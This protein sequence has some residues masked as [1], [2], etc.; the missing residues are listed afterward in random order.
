MIRVRLGASGKGMS[1]VPPPAAPGP[2]GPPGPIGPPGPGSDEIIYFGDFSANDGTYRVR[3]LGGSGTFR[4][5]LYVPAGFGVPSSITLIGWPVA[6]IAL[7]G[8]DNV[9]LASEYGNVDAGEQK[10]NHA[11][12]GTTTT[13]AVLADQL[14]ELD[15][16]SVLTS[17]AE[18]DVVGV[19]VGHV[20]LGTTVM[21]LGIR[22]K[23]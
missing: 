23:M 22:I 21:Y 14:F 15:L 10:D 7:P 16:T 20:A 1:R 3:N 13:G 19:E 9:N 6:N 4:F 11:E 18:G 5:D 2:P 12:T 17:L 8:A